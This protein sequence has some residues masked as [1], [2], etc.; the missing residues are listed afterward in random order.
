MLPSLSSRL[1]LVL[2]L[3]LLAL[4][5]AASPVPSAAQGDHA[6]VLSLKGIINPAAA[7]YVERA[8]DDAHRSG[9]SVIV[10]E[11][12][13]P[14]GLDTSMR[15]IIQKIIGSKVP[16]VVYVSPAGA[17]AGSAGVYIAYAAHVAAMAPS[18]N[19]GSATPVAVGE[20]GEQQMSQEMRNKVTNDAVAYIRGLAESSGRNVDWAERAVRDGANIPAREA[21]ELRVVDLIAPDI[22]ALLESI[23]GREVQ[24]QSGVATLE[25]K[26]V[27]VQRF[28]M[29][30]LESLLHI[31]S[32]PT[33]AYI[34]LSLGTLGLFFELSNPG[35]I[36]PGVVGGIFLLVALFGLGTLPIN[37]AGL[38]LIGFAL[39]L[40]AADIFA[41]THGVLTA[42]G[43]ISFGLGSMMLINTENAPFLAISTTAIVTVTLS[44]TAFSVLVVG[45]V[46][47][48]R[49]RRPTTGREGMAGQIGRASTPIAPR[50]TV[51][52]EG[53][54]WK[55]LAEA[56]SIPEGKD[57]EVVRM[58]GLTL[59]VRPHYPG[60][61]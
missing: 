25:T 5:V 50:G 10:L 27:P 12:D 11:I 56:E 22:P 13:T 6:A 39:L 8:I 33:I 7:S 4:A 15:A 34:L 52:M 58:D 26:G 14:G 24:L 18:T 48:T 59:V 44:I 23:D 28:D 36:F 35:S 32:D 43:A 30:P 31:I 42:G 51:F 40:F 38:L 46:V 37:I 41:P 1:G 54:N 55:A 21:V 17:R 53:T 9:A 60:P 47:R 61:S 20:G 29:T 49:R 57:V 16:V 3:L 2:R 19:I 45:A